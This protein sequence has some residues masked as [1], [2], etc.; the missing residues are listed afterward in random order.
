M[1]GNRWKS[2][3]GAVLFLAVF[4]AAD[5]LSKLAAMEGLRGTKGVTLIPGIL[6]LTYVENPGSA[7]G[8]LQGVQWLVILLSFAL[9]L[10]VIAYVT[11]LPREKRWLPLRGTL[12]LL[13]SG[14]LGNVIDRMTRGVVIDF[15]EFRFIS[16]P[17]FNVADV[18]VT[19]SVGLLLVLCMFVYGEEELFPSRG[20]A[21]K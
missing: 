13:A 17:V 18:Y 19:V 2:L 1:N 14:A 4:T 6:G 3:L 5:Q 7:W 15:F 11:L 20:R 12:L 21:E 10:F 16:F 9:L 8:M